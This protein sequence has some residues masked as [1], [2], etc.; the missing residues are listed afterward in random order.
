MKKLLIIISGVFGLIFL[1]ALML[2]VLFK[3]E[4]KARIDEALEQSIDADVHSNPKDFG[5][6]FFSHFPHPT[7]SLSDLDIVG[8]NAFESDT[9]LAVRKMGITMDLFSLFGA[10]L[11]IKSL[12]FEAPKLTIKVLADG[13][14]NYDIVKNGN[15]DT[16]EDV[17]DTTASGDITIGIDDWRIIDGHLFYIDD[18]EQLIVELVDVNHRGKGDFTSEVF[19]METETDAARV[20]ATYEGIGWLSGQRI[21]AEMA[22]RMNMEEMTF[23]FLDNTIKINDFPLTFDG[24]FSM[25]DTLTNLDITFASKDASVK[26]FYS[27]IPAVYTEDFSNI[28][29]SGRLSFG[30]HV[31]GVYDGVHMPDFEM[32]LLAEK[33]QIRYPELPKPIKNIHLNVHVAG[34]PSEPEK[35]YISMPTFHLELGDNPIDGSFEMTNLQS[36]DLDMYLDATLNLEEMASIIPVKGLSYKGLLQMNVT[37]TG[38]YDSVQHR[39]PA[40]D[41]TFKLDNGYFKDESL[42]KALERVRLQASV[43][44][45]TGSMKDVRIEVPKFNMVMDGEPFEAT[46]SL[47]D[48]DDYQWDL[49]AIGTVDL[50]LVSKVYPFENTTLAGLIQGNIE[51][52]GRYSDFEKRRYERLPTSGAITLTNI[53]YDAPDLPASLHLSSGAATFTPEIIR[54]ERLTGTIGRSDFNLKGQLNN[55]MEYI[56]REN[57][58]VQGQMDLNSNTLDINEW[59][60]G[61][62]GTPDTLGRA[63]EPLQAPEI[64]KNIDFEFDSFVKMVYYDNLTLQNTRG[65]LVVRNGILDM[66]NLTFDMLGGQVRMN[67]IYDSSNPTKPLFEYKMNVKALSIPSVFQSFNTVQVFAPMAQQVNGDF[68]SDF[69]LS[70]ALQQDLVPDYTSLNGSGVIKISEAFVKESKLAIGIANLTQVNLSAQDL[71]LKDV[72]M[73]ASLKEGRAYVQPFDIM[74]G[75]YKA[76]VSGSIGADGTLDYRV[77]TDIDAGAIGQN[78]NSIINS[79]LGGSAGE[80]DGLIHLIFG[81]TGTYDSPDISLLG[82]TDEGQ[83]APLEDVVKEEVKERAIGKIIEVI[84]GEEEVQDTSGVK[85]GNKKAGSQ[86]DDVKKTIENLFN[87]KKK[88]DN[89]ESPV[90]N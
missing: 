88:D 61:R 48:L 27:L 15:E 54:L 49:T 58:I 71:S 80:A 20:F 87:R 11:R 28:E 36:P 29:T 39:F 31:K 40:I 68:S 46:L 13:T 77:A 70:G 32:D 60:S 18:L 50:D 73:Q 55:Y 26:S 5:F 21:N 17:S 16:P 14:A 81:V 35:L 41:A 22:M 42:P 3:G 76:S 43:R 1:L 56:F 67:G 4:I 7:L 23:T 79:F 45:T 24:S 19:N 62:S 30:G 59:L 82:T 37:A 47:V 34:N 66:S 33:G 83:S 25:K 9:L 10:Q 75:E 57:G 52:S 63:E 44:S 78:V 51:S 6:T 74:M 65:N 86:A 12:N 84:G 72:V 38:V 89:K 85:D 64:P 53:M 90:G 2:P 69:S 8:R